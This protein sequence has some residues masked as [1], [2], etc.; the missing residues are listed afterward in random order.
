MPQT[1]YTIDLLRSFATKNN[2]KV[3][4]D[5]LGSELK[6]TSKI[7]LNCTQCEKETL[8]L[9]FYMIKTKKA[10]CKNC[11]T[12]NSLPLQKKTMLKKYGVE[13]PSQSDEMK[14]KIK[15]T[16]ICNWGV[17]NPA[18]TDIVKEKIKR[19]NIERYGVEYM[20]HVPEFK[21][22]MIETNNNNYGC[23]TVLMNESIKNKI[24]NTNIERYGC[25]NVFKN[26]KIYA[27][28]LDTMQQKYG[29][30]YP[31]QHKSIKEKTKQ[32]CLKKY[33]VEN[34][35]QNPEISEKQLN[36]MFSTKQYTMPS[37]NIIKYQGY[38][39]FAFDELIKNG[40]NENDIINSR[41]DVPIIFYQ[42]EFNKKRRHFVDIFIKSDNLCIEVKS[43]Y[44]IKINSDKIYAKK[45]AAEN[46]GYKYEIWC[47]TK[48]GQR[49]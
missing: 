19:T 34:P 18:K 42:D 26:K 39:N 33:G 38:E 3:L 11:I 4:F 2:I 48:S 43:E 17:D 23:P 41:K 47:Y 27:Q 7:P 31:L 6:C 45:T 20:M 49:I 9:F 16:F 22:K 36:S 30:E 21:Q 32:T 12:I 29:V 35:I 8:K 28:S 5:K 25:D 37:G 44:T 15:K 14:A 10:L 1:K 46:L 13:H 40:I 24:K